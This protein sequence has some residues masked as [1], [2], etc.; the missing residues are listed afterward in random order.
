MIHL[1]G[2]STPAGISF[3]SAAT[4]NGK[5]GPVFSYSRS[6]STFS[7]NTFFADLSDPD[8][9]IPPLLPRLEPSVWVSFAPIWLFAPFL[10]RIRICNPDALKGVTGVIACSSS[11]AITKRFAS[12]RYD[13]DLSLNLLS[14]ENLLLETC[15]N[16]S[17]P[18]HVVQPTLIYGRVGKYRDRN[19]SKLLQ[20]L[21]CFPV[22]PLPA[23]T[24]LRQPIHASQLAAAFIHIAELITLPSSTTCIPERIALGGDTTLS[25]V[26]MIRSLKQT[27]P[28]KHPIR[29]SL[30]LFFPNRLFFLFVS[31]LMLCSPK[32]FEAV[33]RMGSNLSGFTP[34]HQFLGSEPHPFPVHPLV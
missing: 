1:F 6:P 26:D 25:Y 20:L 9:F 32:L 13:R 31:P 15:R 24:G 8:N 17:I 4:S 14:F 28:L 33:F 16:L 19:L 7:S 11:S 2:P 22:L 3:F 34:V 21:H 18:G 23:E 12:N 27:Y 29:R 30:L 10:E 5:F